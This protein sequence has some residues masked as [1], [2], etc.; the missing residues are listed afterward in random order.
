M[1]F[2]SQGCRIKGGVKKKTKG[3]TKTEKQ[4]E[5]KTTKK[6]EKG[7]WPFGAPLCVSYGNGSRDIG[8]ILKEFLA[9]E[10]SK[11]VN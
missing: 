1:K 10:V 5:T 3:K 9:G 11:L 2:R 8:H 6:P 4:R 7:F